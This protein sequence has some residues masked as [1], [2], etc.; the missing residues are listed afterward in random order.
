[1]EF[2]ELELELVGLMGGAE[3]AGLD[4][5]Y[6]EAEKKQEALHALRDALDKV[7]R[8]RRAADK[9]ANE[10]LFVLSFAN[11]LMGLGDVIGFLDDIRNGDDPDWASANL[12]AELKH[13]ALAA[14]AAHQYGHD[15]FKDGVSPTLQGSA[16][17]KAMEK[18]D[19]QKS[20]LVGR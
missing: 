3:A 19:R 7:T 18:W 12:P 15:L 2:D 20:K 17:V 1:M 6:D 11:L 9:T 16:A 14:K 8:G 13:V 5:E 10:R 4:D